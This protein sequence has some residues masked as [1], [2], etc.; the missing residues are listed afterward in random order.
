MD[1]NPEHAEPVDMKK[2]LAPIGNLK[3]HADNDTLQGNENSQGVPAGKSA[4][5][6]KTKKRGFFTGP[7]KDMELGIWK[8][9]LKIKSK[10]LILILLNSLLVGSILIVNFIVLRESGSLFFSINLIAMFIFI[11]PIIMLKYGEYKK[12]KELEEVFP[13]FLRD[14]VESIRGGMTVPRALKS[15]TRN[16]YKALN[17]HVKKMSAQLDWGIPVEKVL[18]NFAK[19]SK[20]KLISRII[21]SVRES[22][23]FG[24]NL[25][26]TLEALSNTAVEVEHLREERRLYLHSQMI[27]GYIVFFVFLAVMIGL[28]KFLVPSLG[29]VSTGLPGSEVAPKTNVAM[30]YKTI[31]RN[32]ILIQG[33]FAGLS[34]G[35]M[36]EGAL[37]AGLKHS[38]FMMFIGLLIFTIA[39]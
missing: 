5:V 14:F 28:E 18:M 35:K 1:E 31:F 39:G 15:V 22:H 7:S 29:E 12:T 33:L 2:S 13:V 38:M 16:D 4:P 26:D 30:E 6:K 19:K 25:A 32:L 10:M 17:P 34:T 23:R 21:S 20:S 11:F 27:T 37:I 9:K 3:G 36:S 24:G 8:F